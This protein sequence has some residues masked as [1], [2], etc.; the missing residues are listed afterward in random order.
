M[1]PREIL[2]REIKLLPDALQFENYRIALR[3]TPLGRLMVNSLIISTLSS[4]SRVLIGSLAAFSFAFFEFR[5]KK[6]LFMLCMSTIMIPFD[7]VLISNY[8]TVASMRL[9]DTYLGMMIIFLVS[10]L[11]IFMIR[12]CF[13]SIAKELFEAGKIDGCSNFRIYAQ[14]LLPVSKPVLATVF[15][16]SFVS[17]WNTY[18][19]PMLVTNTD[20][21]RTVQVGIAMLRSS[22]GGTIHGPIMA[23]S[24]LVLI[25]T[26]LVFVIFQKQIVGGMVSGAVKG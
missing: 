2:V 5:G 9:T 21:M 25:P 12:Q 6:F 8:S 24:T 22:D 10:V 11:N 13:L 15:I 17:V 20:T 16:T 4:V 18:L 14:I 23:A 26:V 7:V 19:W 3:L 1:E